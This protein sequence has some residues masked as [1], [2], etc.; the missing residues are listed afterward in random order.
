MRKPARTA[1]LADLLRSLACDVTALPHDFATRPVRRLTSDS[2]VARPGDLFVAIRGSAHDGHHY[3]NQAAQGGCSMMV[4][5]KGRCPSGV[6]PYLIEV[7]DSRHAWAVLCGNW[8]GNPAEEL[9]M[10]GVTGTN[11]KTSVAYLVE[12]LLLDNGRAAGVISTVESRYHDSLGERIAVPSA[13]TTPDPL[14]LHSLL[15]DMVDHGVSHVVMETS[16]HALD[17]KRLDGILYDFALFTNLSWDHLDYHRSMNAYFAAKKKLFTSH[18]K[19]KGCGVVFIDQPEKNRIDYGAILAHELQQEGF[20]D[21]YATNSGKKLFTCGFAPDLDLTVAGGDPSSSNLACTVTLPRGSFSFTSPLMGRL[22]LKNIAMAAATGVCLEMDG[23]TI[24]RA[25]SRPLTIPGRLEPITRATGPADIGEHLLPRVIVDFAHTPEGLSLVLSALKQTRPARLFCVFGCGGDRD[26]AKRQ[27]MGQAAAEHADIIII[28]SDN[29]RSEDPAAICAEIEKGL[30]ESGVKKHAGIQKTKK[31]VTP[32]YSVV[33]SRRRAIR[34]AL[35]MAGADDLVVVCGKG[36]EQFQIIK[37]RRFHF[38]DQEIIRRHLSEWTIERVSHACAGETVQQGTG[39]KIRSVATDSRTL[40]ASALFVTLSGETFNGAGF[41][42]DAVRKGATAIVTTCKDYAKNRSHIPANVAVVTVADT[43][44]ALGDLAAY[45]RRLL[46]ELCGMLVVAVTGSCGK[47]TVKEMVAA[48]I[49][50][51]KQTIATRGNFNNLIGLPLS[52]LPADH[53]CQVAIL[54]MGM[55]TPGEIARLTEIAAPDIAC[56]TTIQ[57]AHLEGL[58]TIDRIAAAKEELF[59]GSAAK[60]ILAINMDDLRVAERARNYPNR[61]ITYG[62]TKNARQMGTLVT[63]EEISFADDGSRF[64]LVIDGKTAWIHLP[65]PGEHMVSDALAAAAICTG[66]AIDVQTIAK[67]L[68]SFAMLEKRMAI[69]PL[70]GGLQLINDCY[71]ANPAS[72]E[73]GLRTLARLAAGVRSAVLLGDM[74]EL[75]EHAVAAH[76]EIGRLAAG[77]GIDFVLCVGDLSRYSA[78]AAILAGLDENHARFFDSR[79]DASQWLTH[80]FR[81]G[82]LTRGDWLLVKG[83]RGMRLEKIIDEL[84]RLLSENETCLTAN[85]QADTMPEASARH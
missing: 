40:A 52:L 85:R 5:E 42:A 75:G 20:T 59:A 10:I 32:W 11:G 9:C 15:R 84:E 37:G 7:E 81:T 62:L 35:D 50:D 14:Q 63:A 31:N 82:A 17:Q 49:R 70:P 27:L 73:A 67:G 48:V 30:L 64:Q 79:S 25:L 53:T 69:K 54:E 38:S 13:L 34:S 39:K 18:L 8:F 23:T 36:H 33:L 28:T 61:K 26:Q 21:F 1:R 65:M 45:R 6:A 44:R 74:L 76:M 43:L 46:G 71:N 47:T 51:H 66:L 58:G 22:N 4:V 56:I 80:L 83:S 78:Q 72:M 57:P 12:Q 24:A 3:V 19:E 29:P 55:N 2:R 41:I 77:L 16:S 60:T 68:N